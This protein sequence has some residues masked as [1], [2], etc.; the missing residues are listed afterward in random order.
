MPDSTFFDAMETRA[1]DAREAELFAQLQIHIAQA[2]ARAPYLAALLADVDAAAVTNRAALA[3]LPLIRKSDLIDIQKDA[4][5]FGGLTT[6]AAGAMGRIFMSPGPIFD[7]EARGSDPWRTAR[8]I[9]AAGFRA[10]DIAHNCFSYH[11]TPAGSMFES[12]AQAIGCAV[13]PAGVGNTETQVQAITHLQPRGYLGTP[14]YLKVI[15]EKADEMG[16]PPLSIRFGH[17]T[18][19]AFLPDMQAYYRERGIAVYQSYGTADAGLIAYETPA[20]DGLVIEERV[21]VEIVRPGT[22]DPLPEGEVGEVVVTPLAPHYPLIRFATGDLS[23]LLPGTGTSACGRTNRRIRGWLGRAD[24]TTKVKGMF[25]HPRQIAEIIGRHAAAG[26]HRARLVVAREGDSD[27]MTLHCEV[28][29]P[30]AE[31]LARAVSDSLQAVTK[32]KG[33]IALCPPGTLPNDGKVID[34]IRA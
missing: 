1:P 13:V 11:F 8:G 16:V 32:L 20:R 24:Q 19:G 27:S 30:G 33:A 22:G 18:G 23:A 14:D 25:V 31:G 21:I 28:D 6:R 15:L 5:P 12:G 29:N 34:D 2:K 4:P 17:V 3:R 7:P 10:G 9:Y 26:V